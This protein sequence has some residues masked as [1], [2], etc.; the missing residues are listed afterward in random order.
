[1]DEDTVRAET[2]KSKDDEGD[3]VNKTIS[4]TEPA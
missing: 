4:V 2:E 1:V 3:S